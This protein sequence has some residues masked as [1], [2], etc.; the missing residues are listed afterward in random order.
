MVLKAPYSV[1]FTTSGF[2][3]GCG[4]GLAVR[5]VA[6]VIEEMNFSEKLL[7][8]LDVACGSLAIDAWKFDTVMAAH[9]RPLPVALGIK[10]TRPDHP[11]MAYIG[12]GAAYSIGMAE[13]MHCGLRNDNIVAVV[14]NNN[15]YGMTGG[16]CAPTSLPGQKT[17]STPYGKDPSVSGMP[18]RIEQAFS[19]FKVG[20][21]ARGAL[22]DAANIIKSKKMLRT[23][24]EKHMAGDGLCLVELLSPCPTNLNLT[25]VATMEHISNEVIKYF[26]LGEFQNNTREALK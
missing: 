23:A 18:F 26:P 9:G 22:C 16:Q 12:D 19:G 4:H 17:T 3:T 2:C 21:L 24:F 20:Y 13:M 10:K 1:S 5:L 6:E 7:A 15:V 25:P 11:V 8:V 14:I